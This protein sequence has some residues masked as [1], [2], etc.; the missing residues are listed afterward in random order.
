MSE[1]FSG[2]IEVRH[3]AG[4]RRRS[5]FS[6]A[7]GLQRCWRASGDGEAITFR[8][9][10]L[11]HPDIAWAFWSAWS[12]EN[13][14]IMSSRWIRR[15]LL[16]KWFCSL[17]CWWRQAG[18][19]SS[20]PS[21]QL[22]CCPPTA[23]RLEAEML[24]Q[25]RAWAAWPFSFSVHAVNTCFAH[26]NCPPTLQIQHT[27]LCCWLFGLISKTFSSFWSILFLQAL[28]RNY[29]QC[30][31]ISINDVGEPWFILEANANFS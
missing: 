1:I 23:S 2:I 3:V 4:V 24:S 18:C 5:T 6:I 10:K 31:I 30:C 17:K 7:G 28:F 26:A 9:N 15:Q 12:A 13:W 29:L 19:V 11:N 27:C 21:E 25:A 8:K 16:Q 20:G 22:L 14:G